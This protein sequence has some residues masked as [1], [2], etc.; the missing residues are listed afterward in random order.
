MKCSLQ[1]K[2]TGERGNEFKVVNHGGQL[3]HLQF[4]LVDP[5]WPL[6]ADTPCYEVNFL[7]NFLLIP[8]Y[9]S[10][11]IDNQYQS[12][13]TRIFAIDWSSINIDCHRLSI[14]SIGYA[15]ITQTLLKCQ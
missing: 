12:I 9:L 7:I 1:N 14:P 2:K 4:E 11:G 13:T 15:G 8:I 10:I 6:L 5:L 3:S